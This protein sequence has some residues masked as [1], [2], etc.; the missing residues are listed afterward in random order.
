MP[1][2]F[3]L[4]IVPGA[5]DRVDALEQRPLDVEPLDDRLDDPVGAREASRGRCRSRR[6]VI[7]AAA[8]AVKN[9]SGLSARARFSPSRATVAGHVEQQDRNAGVGE[10]RGDLRAHRAGAEH[11]DRPN[12]RHHPPMLQCA[13]PPTAVIVLTGGFMIRWI[14]AA[15]LVFTCST[16][17][18]RKPAAISGTVVDETGGG[19]PGATVQLT[20]PPAA[21]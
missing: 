11:R 13:V 7:S 18:A 14:A 12:Q 6:C 17:L 1:D 15:C 19:V 4:T 20:G 5:P 9:G 10:V 8:S 21:I 2:V 3:E 16:S